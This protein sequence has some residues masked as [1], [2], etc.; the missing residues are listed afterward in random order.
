MAFNSLEYLKDGKVDFVFYS[1]PYDYEHIINSV[2]KA[3]NRVEIING[4]LPK[5]KSELPDFCFSIIHD[6]PEFMDEAHE[7]LNLD[8]LTGDMLKNMLYNS[9]LGLKIIS[10]NFDYFS[11]K[12]KNFINVI[13]KYAFDS[14]NKDLLHKLSRNSDLHM[15][16]LFMDYLIENN[17]EKIDEIYDDITKYTTSTTF[18]PL[19]QITYFS[20]LMNPED[21]SKLAV[22]LLVNNRDKDYNKLKEFI[23]KEYKFNYLAS[24]LLTPVF[25]IDPNTHR[26]L[27]DRNTKKKNIMFNENSDKLF[28][29]SADYKFNIYLNYKDKIKKDLL[30]EFE[31]RIEY[32]LKSDRKDESSKFLGSP[33]ER[34]LEGI[35]N[36]GLG[37]L[38]EEWTEKY[39]DLS[40]SKEFGFV[41]GG[42][43]C[44]C[45][46]IGDYVIKLVKTKWSYEEEICPNLYLIAKNYEEIYVRNNNGIVESGLEVQKYLTRAAKGIDK[47]YFT[48]FDRA[49][50]EQGYYRTDTLVNGPCGENA[51]LLDTYLDADCYNPESLP[52]WFKECPIVLV[53]RDRIYSKDKEYIK[54]L[55]GGY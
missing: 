41:G 50:E 12:D 35:Y 13:I 25:E 28:I 33:V 27:E 37:N 17:P 21:I 42:T 38:L 54:Q 55:K 53:D 5:L 34:D 46:R 26:L 15:R 2:R 3:S 6:I 29:T 11:T 30:D 19:E 40:D 51:M 10:E 45:Y 16:F 36:N 14:S 52:N 39:M 8:R 43:T 1:T 44:S 47:K 23:F 18:E 9:P 49:L 31:S 22:K 7:L 48:Y 24:E 32:Y 20:K 4:F